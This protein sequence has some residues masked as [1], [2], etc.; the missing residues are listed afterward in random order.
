M[1]DSPDLSSLC[2]C[3]LERKTPLSFNTSKSLQSNMHSLDK[4]CNTSYDVQNGFAYCVHRKHRP[5]SLTSRFRADMKQ[6]SGRLQIAH[7]TNKRIK[8]TRSRVPTIMMGTSMVPRLL[9]GQEHGWTQHAR[10][11][12]TRIKKN[13][14]ERDCVTLRALPTRRWTIGSSPVLGQVHRIKWRA[15][16]CTGCQRTM[17]LA[18]LRTRAA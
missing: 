18:T 14:E 4:W 3:T 10:S 16:A 12:R 5:C 9:T 17:V 8:N 13:R 15:D 11:T 1:D 6:T 7:P 2:L